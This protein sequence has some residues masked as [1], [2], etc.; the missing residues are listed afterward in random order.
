MFNPQHG[1]LQETGP[2]LDLLDL[3]HE[4]LLLLDPEGRIR[5]LN[6]AAQTLYGWTTVEAVGQSAR[7][8]L[9]SQAP[10]GADHL[11]PESELARLGSWEGELHRRTA[12][13]TAL[14]VDV[15][16]RLQRDPAGAV[17]GIIETGRD[18]SARRQA[19]QA[20]RESELRYQNLFHAMAASFWELDFSAVGPRLHTLRAQGVRDLRQYFH[21]H[22][23][24]VRA[25]MRLTRINRVNEQT[26]RLFG[27]GDAQAL[28]GSV[29]PYWPEA[30]TAVFADSVIAAVSHAPSHSAET[31]L[32]TRDGRLLDVLFTACFTEE[33]VRQGLLL[34]GI[35]DLSE[36][37]A[38]R[39]AVERMQ[40]ELAHASRVSIL[41]ELTASIAHEV[42][43]PL[44]AITT[45]AEAGLRWLR[46]H[47][48]DL[49]EVRTLTAQ[50]VADAR[51]AAD[52][53]DR[54][55]SMAVR[56]EPQR[57]P[58]QLAEVIADT[59]SLLR[60]EFSARGIQV[61]VHAAGGL[62]PVQADRVQVQ[63]V[64]VN[65]CLNAVQAMAH[66]DHEQGPRQLRLQASPEPATAGVAVQVVDTGP[67]IPATHRDQ[68][69]E[70]LY[71]T[72]PG[73]MGMGLRICRSI[74]EAHGGQITVAAGPQ[75]QGAAFR[76]VLPCLPAD[77]C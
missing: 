6:R 36:Q 19:E 75:A 2:G 42:N 60:H 70:P 39:L 49:D 53:I 13:G 31:R 68:V 44:A 26:I 30:S 11:H 3:I 8:L 24:Q 71:T 55:R 23:D 43:Q 77:P 48:P 5:A 45:Q 10:N 18:M 16:W 21:A 57:Q 20:L 17:I 73:G 67:G 32:R 33:A 38:A 34:V 28:C 9:H 41:G 22:P 59:L 61:Q 66:P 7:L 47:P 52:I 46:R 58:L 63:Q 37:V 14:I 72:K 56:G 54:V 25:L 65:L 62:P 69:F 12:T 1:I 35:I 74:I 29:E 51:R 40:A 76:F 27:G 4:S 15:R 64:L 50:I